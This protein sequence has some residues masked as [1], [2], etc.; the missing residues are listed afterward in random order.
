MFD[1]YLLKQLQ[2]VCVVIICKVDNRRLAAVRTVGLSEPP[3]GQVPLYGSSRYSGIPR[4]PTH[5][6]ITRCLHVQMGI[7]QSCLLEKMADQSCLSWGILYEDPVQVGYM[8]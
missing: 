2:T 4:V 1:F 3:E 6:I 7:V 5:L 8:Q